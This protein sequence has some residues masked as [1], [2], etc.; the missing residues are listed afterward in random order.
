M[1]DFAIVGG[2]IVGL[3]TARALLGRHPNAGV[4]V[5]EKE[6]GWAR[7]QT[8]HNSGVIH[9]GVYYKPGSLK[10]RFSREGVA[11]LLE[12]CREQRIAFEICGK[13]IVATKPDELPR[14]DDLY[15]RGLKNGL[16]VEKIGPNELEELEPHAAGLAALK[17]PETGIVDFTQVAE[18]FATVVEEEGGVLR[19]S[20]E[21]EYVSETEG[22]VEISTNRGTFRA[23][24]LINC[25][26]LHS[27]RVAL[28]CGVETGVKIV[29]FRGEYYELKPE[30]RH[31]VKNII[32][33]LP[34]PSFPF[35]NVHLTRT[36]EGGVEAGPNAVLGLAREG[37]RK[38]DINIKD[39]CEAL[40]YPGLWRLARTYWR[41]GIRELVRSFSRKVFTRS[42][43]KLVPEIEEE[44]LAPIEAGVRAQALAKDGELVNDFLIVDGKSS[45]HV[46]NAPSPAAT[47]AI[48]IGETIAE[49]ITERTGP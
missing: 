23:R 31:L 1:F 27:D 30:K 2:G 41:T 44:D 24:S 40:T 17:V 19:T 13:V 5:L 18:A 7:H 34:D 14:L 4:L 16:K 12:F 45:V 46:L 42:L 35:L 38:T 6:E 33:P 43:K 22:E 25:A 10:A 39:S 36:V 37:Y 11:T 8:G 26:G 3:S 21:V 20:T 49:R 15:E 28:L 32:Y 47:A 29:P 48:P 9:S